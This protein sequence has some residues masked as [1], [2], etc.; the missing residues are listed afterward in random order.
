M[1]WIPL[2]VALLLTA[3]PTPEEADPCDPDA[4]PDGRVELPADA[5]PRGYV[6]LEWWYWTGHLQADDGRW[7]GFEQVFFLFDMGEFAQLAQAAVTDIDSGEHHRDG[8][9]AF[10]EPAWTEGGFELSHGGQTASGGDGVDVLH[11]V[12][13]RTTLDLTLTATRAPVLHHGDGYHEYAAGGWTYYYSRTR[14]AAAGTLVLDDETIPVAGSGWFDRQWGDLTAASEVGWDWFALQLDDGTDVMIFRVRDGELA[15]ATV[16]SPECV[17]TEV[18][19]VTIVETG[20]W[21]SPHH[22]EPC[23]YP[24][25]WALQVGDAS[26]TV[27]PVLEDQEM[28]DGNPYWEGA[29]LVSGDAGGRAYVELAGYC[30]PAHGG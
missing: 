3:C 29:A 5:A 13:E 23:T 11:G 21:E 27:T 15:G 25:G 14:M 22:D 7:F 9:F 18:D 16:V 17:V 2:L 4:L 19:D 10:A 26:Y 24:S 1:R 8:T 12:T 20:S 6:P 30:E 28:P